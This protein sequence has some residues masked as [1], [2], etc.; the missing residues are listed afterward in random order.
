MRFCQQSSFADCLYSG[1]GRRAADGALLVGVVT[2]RNSCGLIEAVA[3]NERGKWH[4]PAPQPLTQTDDVGFDAK[5]FK[6]E[7]VA[8]AAQSVGD[9][10]DNQQHLVAIADLPHPLP[11]GLRGHLHIGVADGLGDKGADA[12]LLLDDVIQIIGVVQVITLPAIPDAAIAGGGGMRSTPA[13]KG[14]MPAR[15]QA[16]PP[17]EMAS[18]EAP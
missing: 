8:S 17:T 10:V 9:L 2:E 11:V 3:G 18:R 4:H 5:L 15:K 14:P 7:P 13:I 6:A 1:E 16:S 12:S